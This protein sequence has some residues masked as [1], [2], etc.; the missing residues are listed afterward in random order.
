MAFSN[1]ATIIFDGRFQLSFRNI[2]DEP[3]NDELL[4]I[5]KIQ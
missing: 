3:V 1:P 5:C 2:L 4:E